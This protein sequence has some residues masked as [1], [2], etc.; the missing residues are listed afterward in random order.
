MGL[1]VFTL[2]CERQSLFI[3]DYAQCTHALGFK[4]KIRYLCEV[5]GRMMKLIVKGDFFFSVR[6]KGKIPTSCLS[7]LARVRN[8]NDWMSFQKKHCWHVAG[9]K[10]S[11]HF[12]HR[13]NQYIQELYKLDFSGN[14]RYEFITNE[15][16]DNIYEKGIWFIHYSF[17]D[18]SIVLILIQTK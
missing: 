8:K 13:N 5:W 10:F 2:L 16:F 4:D 18:V 1:I 17:N 9:H 12:I 7:S 11:Y 14:Y 15:I 6:W 3:Q